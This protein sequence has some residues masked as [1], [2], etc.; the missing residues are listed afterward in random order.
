LSKADLRFLSILVDTAREDAEIEI[1][2]DGN[3][4]GEASL[5]LKRI[6][7]IREAMNHLHE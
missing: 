2:I 4:K 6:T 7:S 5:A 1:E 3:N